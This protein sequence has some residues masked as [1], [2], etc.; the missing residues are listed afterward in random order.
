[1]ERGP[2]KGRSVPLSTRMFPEGLASPVATLLTV[3]LVLRPNEMG[4]PVSRITF[5][6]NSR[7]KSQQP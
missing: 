5:C 1:M 2:R 3:L 7:E 6:R 4:N